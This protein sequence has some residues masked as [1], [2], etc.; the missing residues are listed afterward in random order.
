MKT[1]I[2]IVVSAALLGAPM[3]ASADPPGDKRHEEEHKRDELKKADDHKADDKR[4]DVQHRVR[5]ADEHKAAAAQWQDKAR[6]AR[7][8]AVRDPKAWKDGRDKRAD[9]HRKAVADAV[10]AALATPEAQAELKLHADRMARLNRILDV[11]EQK[12]DAALTTR[13]K[14]LIDKEIARDAAVLHDIQVKA[15]A[16]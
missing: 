8:D 15:G 3:L 9:E 10:G 13:A 7:K 4:W 1:F 11:A 5:T 2:P 12:S 16:Q 14:A 6:T